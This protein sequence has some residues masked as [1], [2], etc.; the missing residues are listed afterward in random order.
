[1]DGSVPDPAPPSRRR[2][3]VSAKVLAANRANLAKARAVPKAIRYRDT[4]RRRAAAPPA[5]RTCSKPARPLAPRTARRPVG[6]FAMAS[7]TNLSAAA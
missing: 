7:T 2:Y 4:P 3:T 1:M 6:G 5:T